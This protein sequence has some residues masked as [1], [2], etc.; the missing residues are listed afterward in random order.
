MKKIEW[1]PKYSILPIRASNEIKTKTKRKFYTCA[2]LLKQN[3]TKELRFIQGFRIVNGITEYSV[4]VSHRH[5]HPPN[6]FQHRWGFA[7]E[8]WGHYEAN[9]DRRK[10]D[11]PRC[12]GWRR[13]EA[14]WSESRINISNHSKIKSNLTVISNFRWL[15]DFEIKLKHYIQNWGKSEVA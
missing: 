7:T 13:Y 14:Q 10:V 11:T 5:L 15:H 6:S 3:E 12:P 4:S 9:E 8:F 2:L 1:I